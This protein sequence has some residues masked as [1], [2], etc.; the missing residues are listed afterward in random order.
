MEYVYDLMKINIKN[1]GIFFVL[2]TIISILLY[3]LSIYFEINL[4]EGLDTNSSTSNT[5]N[6]ST[7]QKPGVYVMTNTTYDSNG[8][9]VVKTMDTSGNFSVNT[10]GST[11]VN[12]TATNPPMSSTTQATT[13][14]QNQTQTTSQTQFIPAQTQAPPTAAVSANDVSQI[15]AT[16]AAAAAAAAAQVTTQSSQTSP[17]TTK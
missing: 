9:V 7:Q 2:L 15:A 5:S 16:A 4:Q 3:V 6:T 8:N 12:Q 13:Q 14:T 10:Y 17:P 11:I 1:L